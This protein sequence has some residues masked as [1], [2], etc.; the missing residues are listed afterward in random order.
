MLTLP[1]RITQGETVVCEVGFTDYPA[2]DWTLRIIYVVDGAQT[3]VDAT[4]VGTT[5]AF[6]IRFTKTVTAAMAKGTQH[7]QAFVTDGTD[8]YKV[9]E[10]TTDIVS[11]FETKTSGLDARST[12]RK[13]VDAIRSVLMGVATA[14]QKKVKYADREIEYYDRS[15]LITVYKFLQDELRAEER[16]AKAG[17]GRP[18]G[19]RIRVRF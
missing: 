4:Q 3:I 19:G 6:E 16:A 1:K 15:E 14:E 2:T 8:R 9:G 13:Q 17:E 10:D 11:D 7:W 12:L 18:F 5:N